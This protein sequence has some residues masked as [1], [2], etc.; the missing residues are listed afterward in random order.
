[1][2]LSR[3]KNA[4]S[5]RNGSGQ[6]IKKKTKP[7]KNVHS[8]SESYNFLCPDTLHETK[9]LRFMNTLYTV[10]DIVNCSEDVICNI[11]SK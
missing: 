7:Y 2:Y 1:M 10:G 8:S 3:R 6:I 5:N 11:L 4:P 9:H